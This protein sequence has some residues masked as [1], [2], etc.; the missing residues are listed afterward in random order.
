[1]TQVAYRTAKEHKKGDLIL[2]NFSGYFLKPVQIDSVIEIFP[3]VIEV[4]RRF[5]KIDIEIFHSGA[6]VA[7]AMLT[8]RVIEQS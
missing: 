8:A 2:D 6:R 3:T 5:C 1:M 4:S 7:K